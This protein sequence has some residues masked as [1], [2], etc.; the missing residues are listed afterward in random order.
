MQLPRASATK[1]MKLSHQKSNESR[2]IR[3]ALSGNQ[4]QA[5]T[6]DNSLNILS[7]RSVNHVLIDASQRAS[8]K[9]SQ[10]VKFSGRGRYASRTVS[11]STN[12]SVVHNTV[13]H[14]S[15]SNSPF[16]SKSQTPEWKKRLIYGD[17]AYGEQ[18][19]LFCS[20]ANGLEN[21]F[22]PPAAPQDSPAAMETARAETTLPS[23]PPLYYQRQATSE[24]NVY[25][26]SLQ[27]HFIDESPTR[28]PKTMQYR[29]QEDSVDVS[30]GS[31]FSIRP[32]TNE[33]SDEDRY[34]EE[35]QSRPLWSDD[36]AAPVHEQLRK[37]SGQS[38][39]LNE[40][41]SPILLSRRN[42]EDGR[43]EYAPVEIPADQLRHRLEKLRINQMLLDS[44]AGDSLELNGVTPEESSHGV[45]TTEDYERKGGFLNLRR[46]GRSADGSFRHRLLSPGLGTDT[47][48]MLPEE[49]LQASTPKQFPTVR[50]DGPEP[51]AAFSQRGVLPRAPYPSPEKG[52]TKMQASSGSPLKLFGPY[53]TFT[54]QTLMRRISQFEEQMSGSSRQSLDWA[55]ENSP[56]FDLN[57]ALVAAS[58][59]EKAGNYHQ[60]STIP[61][62]RTV[63]TFGVG[64]LEGFKFNEDMSYLSQEEDSIFQD[65]QEN[66]RPTHHS[67]AN[68]IFSFLSNSSPEVSDDM[69]V[70][71]K[72]PKSGMTAS[73][74]NHGRTF[75][76]TSQQN[77]R[78][79]T[80]AMRS[81]DE[82]LT[83]PKKRDTA[84]DGKR[85]R[86][87]PS[88]DPTPKRRRT[89][90]KSDIAYGRD[91]L[92]LLDSVQ[93]SSLYMQSIMGKK[94]KDARPGDEQQPA[95]PNVLATRQIL[96]PRTPT[97][98]QRSSVQREQHP[99]ADGV[100]TMPK[101]EPLR[102]SPHRGHAN[103]RGLM[104]S[105]PDSETDRK[106]S[107]KTQDYLEEAGKIMAMIRNQVK[108]PSGLTS[109]DES[110][111]ENGVPSPEMHEDSLQES[112]KE[113]FSR[114]PSREGRPVSRMPN[115]QEDPE[116]LDRLKKYQEFSG[117]MGDI[118][119]SSLRSM[120]LAKDAIRSAQEVERQLRESFR[121]HASLADVP[122][123]EIVSDPPNIRISKGPMLQHKGSHPSMNGSSTRDGID[124]PS[125]SSG[126]STNR[127]IPTG[128]SRG[129][130]SKN[131]IPPQNVKHVIPDQLAGMA[132]DA[133]NNIWIK[134]RTEGRVQSSTNV[135]PSEASEDDPF[136]DIPDLSV[137]MTREMQ[138]LRLVA[139][140]KRQALMNL[141]DMIAPPD[142]TKTPKSQGTRGYVTL[143]PD[144]ALS[145]DLASPAR[146]ELEKLE[147]KWEMRNSNQNE[148]DVEHEIR[149]H[150]DRVDR[151]TPSRKRNLTIS[152]SSPIASII[153]DVAP[154][155]ID[156]LEDDPSIAGILPV[157]EAQGIRTSRYQSLTKSAV[158][159]LLQQGPRSTSRGTSRQLS[160]SGRVFVPRPVSRIDERDEDSMEAEGPSHDRQVSLVGER[161][162]ADHFSAETRRTSLNFVLT[163]PGRTALAAVHPDASAIIAQN[164]GNL[165]LTPLSEFTVNQP[166]QSFGF[167]V[168][169]IVGDR[170]METGDGS[171][172]VM[173]MTVR[174]LVDR[175][176]EVEPIEPYWEDLTDLDIH[177]RRLSSLH[178]LDEFCGRL[179][180]LDASSNSLAHL[181][182]VP[183]TIRELKITH[184]HLTELTSWDHLINLQYVDISNNEVRS[185]S[186]LKNL[187]H[188]RSLKADNNQLTSL[189]GLNSLD[190]LL[191]LRAR[192][193]QINELDFD[194]TRLSRLTELDLGGNNVAAIRNI[195][196]LSSLE[197]L[198]LQRNNIESLT[199]DC[200]AG[201]PSLRYLDISDNDVI[202]LDISQMPGLRLLHA[203]RNRIHKIKGFTKARYLDSL[204][205]R[206]QRGGV[207]LD[208]SF[209]AAAYEIRKL[210]LSGNYLG[211]FEPRVDFLNLQLLEL[212]N[213]GLQSLPDNLGQL[214]PNVRSLNL[215]F[216]AIA[217]L[218]PLQF[219]PRLKKLFVAG[220][221]LADSMAVTELL[222]EYP[223]LTQLDLR[224]NPIT[225]GF[226]PPVQVLVPTD[227]TDFV[228]PFVLPDAD[229][230]RDQLFVT[231]IDEAT[232]LR[233]RLY[234][235]VFVSCCKRLKMLD[236]VTVKRQLLLARDSV[237][238][239]LV[240]DGLLPCEMMEAGAQ[241]C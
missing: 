52:A 74:S 108:P 83:T 161:S 142:A 64:E 104:H 61:R 25:E 131:F 149:I 230:E 195:G 33:T 139:E 96:R 227:R 97:P 76:S 39:A 77:L 178:M 120:G 103:G 132:W 233:R 90:H 75:S 167:E 136:A 182:G 175:L 23:S 99:F 159:Q 184:N 91:D 166:D 211:N 1:N 14:K 31:N 53:D 92:G 164:V 106:P 111:A 236:G 187:V 199:V 192:D 128:S 47:S 198:R 45:E 214:M 44:Q 35:S 181:D 57:H 183:S 124:F 186:A 226:Y 171:K 101:T 30:N 15:L 102:R 203:D 62:P 119:T 84:S 223:H 135:L 28:Q 194:G 56:P 160:V 70:S 8:S 237:L 43:V 115:R 173:S 218:S 34:A 231:R 207:P 29:M 125:N 16:K 65:D 6:A 191:T 86:T 146:K 51:Q 88:K 41:F 152:F 109:V 107:I 134:K 105:E 127:S 116:V 205:L 168:S 188:L 156:G 112:T 122:E 141:D 169:Y 78:E 165:S 37:V 67:G 147:I 69:V 180:T 225:L 54:N 13:Q 206:E 32:D 7:E 163:T 79:S 219:I 113:P 229:A 216:N 24:S 176:T 80:T 21:I 87:S 4:S 232:K 5:T 42:D 193:N 222:I 89:L 209:L 189:D 63:S 117:D 151:T 50:T 12:G 155:D 138:N 93:H 94:R 20:A 144:G 148:E 11:A 157:G 36:M 68:P 150:E 215:N 17:V 196:E 221:R 220:N 82:M 55:P 235:V 202:A 143:S 59:P 201:L 158:R 154:E 241:P 100:D 27:E 40:D 38:V 9:L 212:A 95:N 71:K 66:W 26:E 172:K 217:D 126:G 98:S 162:I 121:S 72:R 58:N 118:I 48:E 19:D 228:D 2:P 140:T 123:D 239:R 174:D 210:F 81:G 110:E 145:Q 3:P 137:D 60:P 130:D 224:D 200:A 22:K 238:E 179:V 46:G 197:I 49:S 170:H 73:S 10:D 204:S 114:P 190:G 240:E 129:S 208:L 185:L 213:C 133:E 85:P 153:Q 234:Q 177:D 18:R